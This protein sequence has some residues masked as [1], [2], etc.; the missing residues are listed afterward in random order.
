MTAPL[1]I[2]LCGFAGAGKSTISRRLAKEFNFPLFSSDDFAEAIQQ[3]TDHKFHTATPL[4]YSILWHIVE[5]HIRLGVSLILDSNMCHARSWEHLDDLR[6]RFPETIA[7]PILLE[8]PLEVHKSRIAKR[9]ADEPEHFN[10]GGDV[11][12]DILFKYEFLRDLKR[13]DLI[14]LDAHR[15]LDEV[16]ADAVRIIE[17][18]PAITVSSDNS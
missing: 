2:V 4:A 14:R 5:K 8:C 9:G 1:L 16:Y 10:L 3:N 17:R 15:S 11:F 7:L 13:S 12:D 6:Q 18:P